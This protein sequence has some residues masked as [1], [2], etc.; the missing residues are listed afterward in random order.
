MQKNI[1]Q[2][3]IEV[4]DNLEIKAEDITIADVIK[5]LSLLSAVVKGTEKENSKVSYKEIMEVVDKMSDDLIKE[6]ESKNG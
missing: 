6:E 5:G 2:I 1:K 3:I 4:G